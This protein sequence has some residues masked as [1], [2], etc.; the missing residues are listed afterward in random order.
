MDQTQIVQKAALKLVYYEAVELGID[1]DLWGSSMIFA[2]GSTKCEVDCCLSV[3][4]FNP[5]RM[6]TVGMGMNFFTAVEE[7]LI[8]EQFDPIDI[9]YVDPDFVAKARSALLTRLSEMSSV[10][11]KIKNATMGTIE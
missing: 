11:E 8:F 1:A 3:V 4:A 7:R 2:K 6:M 9:A 5:P 10:C